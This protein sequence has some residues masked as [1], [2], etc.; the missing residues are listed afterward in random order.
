MVTQDNLR[1]GYRFISGIP[2]Y[3]EGV[4]AMAGYEIVHI[5]LHRPLAYRDGFGLIDRYLAAVDRPRQSLCGI[6][7]R[8]P[9]PQSLA[10]FEAFNQD[11]HQLLVEWDLLVE[12]RTPI[13]RTNVVPEVGTPEEPSL[14]AFAY[15]VESGTSDT[16]PSF[17][18]AG[19]GETRGGSL[20]LDTVVRPGE[21]SAEA[22]RDKAMCV[23]QTMLARLSGLG[24]AAAGVTVA[25]VYT[26]REVQPYLEDVILTGLG[27]AAVHGV[28][29]YYTRP[30]ITGIEFEMDVRGVRRE[31]HLAAT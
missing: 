3:S 22:M 20:S 21:T 24:V 13:A 6:Q 28:H 19:A 12:G 5:T 1:G 9:R 2:A 26:V 27:A 7:L 8:S 31:L 14:Y 4:V 11:Y 17:I 16:A 10:G 30:P 23:M 18:V 29:W 15:T 25:N